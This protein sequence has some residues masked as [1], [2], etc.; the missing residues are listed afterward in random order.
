MSMLLDQRSRSASHLLEIA[1]TGI[2]WGVIY[3]DDESPDGTAA[4]I[5]D[6]SQR[7]TRVRCIQ[8]IDRRGLSSAV[9]EGML[10][11]AP[12]TSLSSMPICSMT[13]NCCLG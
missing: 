7:N 8:R 1:L 12:P 6:L 10:R 9:I 13:K 4:K 11:V 3:V 2:E 5:R